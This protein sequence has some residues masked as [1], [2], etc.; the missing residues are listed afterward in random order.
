[1]TNELGSVQITEGQQGE[2]PVVDVETQ[3]VK[4]IAAQ[5]PNM[6]QTTAFVAHTIAEQAREA[7]K[8]TMN[9]EKARAAGLNTGEFSV[10]AGPLADIIKQLDEKES[11]IKRLLAE[12]ERLKGKTENIEQQELTLLELQTIKTKA[13]IF[14]EAY[15]GG[16]IKGTSTGFGDIF[17]NKYSFLNYLFESCITE[18]DLQSELQSFSTP[19]NNCQEILRIFAQYINVLETHPIIR[20]HE[21]TDKGGKA[22]GFQSIWDIYWGKP[23][24]DCYFCYMRDIVLLSQNP[25][26]LAKLAAEENIR[27]AAYIKEKSSLGFSNDLYFRTSSGSD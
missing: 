9:E 25:E 27:L 1:M 21:M 16:T 19:K 18:T 17:G 8:G 26:R 2:T 24:V 12:N 5:N 23:E 10:V 15:A 20:F 7:V 3:R 22:H 11:E 14:L 4:R 13:D 6:Y